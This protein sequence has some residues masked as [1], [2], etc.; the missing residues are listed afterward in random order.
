MHLQVV[1]LAVNS[2][3]GGSMEVGLHAFEEDAFATQ[4]SIE[5]AGRLGGHAG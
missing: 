1:D 4:V 2:V 5:Q 3:F